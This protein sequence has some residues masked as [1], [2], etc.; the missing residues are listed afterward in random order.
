MLGAQ[1]SNVIA[2]QVGLDVVEIKSTDG[3]K[4]G[5]LTAG[6]YIA[7]GVFI[8]YE[9]GFGEYGVNETI[10]EVF[11][12]EYELIRSLFVQFVQANDT[13]SGADIILKIE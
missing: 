7:E 10:P 11:T 13:R 3:T 6:K 2:Q 5:T 12:I 1:L 9:K 8:S 4:A